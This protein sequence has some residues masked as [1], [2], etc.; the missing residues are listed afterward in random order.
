MTSE[1]LEQFKKWFYEYVSTFYGDDEITNDNIRLKED[2]TRRM[3]ADTG[4]IADELGFDTQFSAEIG[5]AFF[6]VRACI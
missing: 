2:H 1:Q 4:L 6:L 3:C 5:R